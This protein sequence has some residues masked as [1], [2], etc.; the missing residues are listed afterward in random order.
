MNDLKKID[1]NSAS[2][3][4]NDERTKK[5]A[6]KIYQKESQYYYVFNQRLNNLVELIKKSKQQNPKILECGFGGG[7]LAEVLLKNNLC[8]A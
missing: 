3:F 1:K 5:W 8:Y 7:Q 6:D 4:W 2:A